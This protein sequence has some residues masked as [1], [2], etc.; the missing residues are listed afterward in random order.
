MWS[1]IN[2]HFF[3]MVQKGNWFIFKFFH[4]LNV[5]YLILPEQPKQS[6]KLLRQLWNKKKLTI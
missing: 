3:L 6:Q 4:I 5:K 1:L 2:M